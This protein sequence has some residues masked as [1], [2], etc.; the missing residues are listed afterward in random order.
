[1]V[2]KAGESGNPAGRKP[3]SVNKITRMRSQ[4][5]E[6]VL[7]LVMA[8]ALGG[9]ASAQELILKMGM[10]PLKAIEA[11]VEFTLP[12]AGDPSPARAV[13]QQA[14]AGEISLTHAE[15]IVYD[16]MP[17][18]TQEEKALEL[19]AQPAPTG[20]YNAYLNSVLRG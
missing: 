20:F 13:L 11:P 10:P 19:K 16:L 15:K 2:W 1:M 17:A 12:E 14:A 3:G 5:A 4:A 18:V 9:D 8:R 7:P 6:A